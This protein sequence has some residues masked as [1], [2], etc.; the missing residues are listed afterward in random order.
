MEWKLLNKFKPLK[1]LLFGYIDIN[2]IDGS[3]FFLPGMANMLTSIPNVEVDLLLAR[4]ARRMTV[5]QEV[6]DNNK[7]NVIDP[8]NSAYEGNSELHFLSGV[9]ISQVQAAELLEYHSKTYEYDLKI[10]RSTEV[11]YHATKINEDFAKNSILYVTGVVNSS[12]L[13]DPDTKSIFEH[14]NHLGC[15]FLLQTNEMLEAF[16]GNY[17]DHVDH[18]ISAAAIYPMVPDTSADFSSTFIKKSNY[19]NFV[20]TGKFVREWNPAEI[21]SAMSELRSVDH[22]ATLEVAGDQF[23]RTEE[24]DTFVEEVRYLLENTLGVTWHGGVDREHARALIR[25]AD[26]GISWRHPDLDDSLELSTKLLEYGTLAKPCIMNRTP[27]HERLFGSDYPLYAN[28]MTEFTELLF[29]IVGD[30]EIVEFAAERSFN[31]SLNF[32]YSRAAQRMLPLIVSVLQKNAFPG[33]AFDLKN[34]F[35]ISLSDHSPR[36]LVEAAESLGATSVVKVLGPYLWL[37]IQDEDD[38][39]MDLLDFYVDWRA[40]LHGVSS[41][42]ARNV[43]VWNPQLVTQSDVVG[44]DVNS[45]RTTES[46]NPTNSGS[47]TAFSANPEK[48]LIVLNDEVARR[49]H[50]I[51]RLKGELLQKNYRIATLEEKLENSEKRLDALRTSRLGKIQ[52]AIWAK[53]K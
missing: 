45:G 21:L 6:L 7:V 27:M 19:K 11:A 14:L 52:V 2:V 5:L 1:I 28:T 36:S 33:D 18:Q 32:T 40:T 25:R 48:S 10:I 13:I 46:G 17:F 26:V 39:A 50:E 8:F 49:Y 3:A 24:N 37:G 23:R 47:P 15:S 30:P 38:D 34:P 9:S 22:E 4:P 29:K 31:V 53:R 44:C 43:T 42:S 35:V 12:Q 20:Y 51:E 16:K 41:D